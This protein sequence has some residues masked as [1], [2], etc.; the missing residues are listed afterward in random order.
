MR[1]E[2]VVLI[3]GDGS[4]PELVAAARRVLDAGAAVA[5]VGLDWRVHLAG[6]AALAEHG[7][8]LPADSLAAVR[9]VGV[10]LKGPLGTPLGT[11]FRS[12]NLE[13]RRA[14]DLFACVRP[15]RSRAGVPAYLAGRPA[16]AGARPV[17][18]VLVR[19]NVEDV[20]TGLEPAAGTEA[21]RRARRLAGPGAAGGTGAGPDGDGAVTLRPISPGGSERIARFAFGYARRHGRRSVSCGVDLDLFPH[22]DGA[23]EA[24]FRAA[25]G[26]YPDLPSPVLPLAELCRRLVREPSTLDVVVLP[27]LYGD[28]LSD[29][30]AAA[31][32]GLGVAPSANLGPRAAIF[33]ATH[34]TAPAFAGTGRLNP[35]A[36]ILAGAMMLDH[37]GAAGA[38]AAVERA[39]AAVLTAG[40]T[41]TED[42]R[43]LAPPATTDAFADAIVS[44]LRRL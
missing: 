19:E 40:E 9:D 1:R 38:A 42:L 18:L 23:F 8:P 12:I 20:Y 26:A 3:P 15:C 22:T 10:A 7:R 35:T 16:A 24:G 39:T 28:V 41:V 17:D 5:G 6:R 2:P 30:A 32:G 25:A 29:A 14:L 31:V 36:L 21:A 4:G 34:G 44:R 43:P 37:L 27:N 13:L 33:E 11:G